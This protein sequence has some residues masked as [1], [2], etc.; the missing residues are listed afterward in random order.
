M[1]PS[2]ALLLLLPSLRVRRRPLLLWDVYVYLDGD[3]EGALDAA[4]MSLESEQSR[5]GGERE[6]RGA[7]RAGPSRGR[8]R[9]EGIATRIRRV[10]R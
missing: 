2:L 4:M 5:G 1:P 6:A 3:G 8:G 9:A 10:Q 7:H